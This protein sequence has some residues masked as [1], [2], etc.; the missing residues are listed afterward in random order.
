MAVNT[1]KWELTSL[2]LFHVRLIGSTLMTHRSSSGES[3]GKIGC[4]LK[5]KKNGREA[6]YHNIIP[7]S[8]ISNEIKSNK[9]QNYI[10]QFSSQAHI[11]MIC[12]SCQISNL[13]TKFQK[14][15]VPSLPSSRQVFYDK[16]AKSQVHD[17]P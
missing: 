2:I 8:S 10:L 17:T 6:L 16:N 15:T 14:V 11:T 5:T 3:S 12:Q 7:K 9:S 1:H 4:F 13:I